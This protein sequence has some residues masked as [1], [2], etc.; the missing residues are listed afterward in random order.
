MDDLSQIKE[1]M[2]LTWRDTY[3]QFYT[4]H[5]VERVINEFQTIDFLTEQFKSDNSLFSVAK[6]S[7]N[8]IVGVITAFLLNDVVQIYRLYI[9]PSYRSQ[10]IG[11][12]LIKNI[13]DHFPHASCFRVEVKEENIRAIKFYERFVFVAVDKK[14]HTF[15]GETAMNLILERHN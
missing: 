1:V 6:T 13:F 5:I 7:E 10:K 14:E 3:T 12:S 8:H 2:A 15:F 11:E 9:H 4:A